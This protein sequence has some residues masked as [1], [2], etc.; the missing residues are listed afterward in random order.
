[1]SIPPEGQSRGW[2][3][4][5]FTPGPPESGPAMR[6]YSNLIRPSSTPPPSA[7]TFP[8]NSLS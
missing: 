4:P 3:V 8:E 2:R 7:R 5:N 6:S 1:M